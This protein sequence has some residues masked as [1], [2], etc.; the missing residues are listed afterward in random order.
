MC[1]R[2]CAAGWNGIFC[3]K[4]NTIIRQTLICILDNNVIVAHFNSQK[5]RL[6]VFVTRKNDLNK[7]DLV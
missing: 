1:D 7:K 6:H 5:S 4:G 3:T 2:G